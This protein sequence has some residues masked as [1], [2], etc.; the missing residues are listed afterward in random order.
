MGNKNKG[1]LHRTVLIEWITIMTAVLTCFGI[2]YSEVK[3]QG[4]RID[5]NCEIHHAR[6]DKLYEMFIDLLKENRSQNINSTDKTFP[7]TLRLKE[8]K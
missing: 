4:Q 5:R 1:K 3:G 7:S 2:L 6:A 8:K